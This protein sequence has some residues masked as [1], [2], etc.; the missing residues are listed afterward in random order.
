MF[1]FFIASVFAESIVEQVNNDPTSTWVAV[2]Y[3]PSIINHARFIARLGHTM[4]QIPA[5]E[6]IYRNDV[7]ESFDSRDQWPGKILPVRNQQQCGSCWAFAIAECVGDR[8]EVAGKGQGDMSPQDLVSC[9]KTDQACNGGEFDPAWTW[10]RDNGITTDQCLPYVSGSG[11]VPQCPTK[12]QNGSEIIRTKVNSY[13]HLTSNEIQEEIIAH[14]PVSAGFTVYMDFQFY[15]SGV[16]KHK[17]P[18]KA[19]GHAIL[20]IGWGVEKNTP[21]W[22][23][24][25]S[26][27]NTWGEKGH[28]KI[29]RGKNECG[30]EQDVYTGMV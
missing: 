4:S 3:H 19:G 11:R 7:P 17:V 21:Y 6:Y 5:E 16:Y 12:C 14:G 29:L 15:R 8:L 26:W 1:F 18:I 27:G 9:D 13:K 20:I 23:C 25:N 28:F 22:L 30:I 24:Q 10:T 2:E